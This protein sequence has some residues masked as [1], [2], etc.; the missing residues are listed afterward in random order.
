MLIRMH[1]TQLR[2]FIAL[3]D[4]GSFTR[5]AG[6]AHV[7]QPALSRSI[8]ML[9]EDLGLRLVDRLGKRCQVSTAGQAV[10]ARARRIVAEADELKRTGEQLR[11]ALAGQ[12][13]IGLGGGPGAVLTTALLKHFA[14]HHPAIRLTISRAPTTLLLDSLRE[15]KID[16]VVVDA[17]AV[18]PA[19]DLAIDILPEMAAGFFCRKGHPLARRKSIGPDVLGEFPVASAPLSDEISRLIVE[20]FGPRWHPNEFVTLWCDTV[21]STLETAQHTDAIFIGIAAAL[22][23]QLAR[24]RMLCLPLW[25]AMARVGRFGLITLAHRSEPP[26]LP[27]LRAFVREQLRDDP[28]WAAMPQSRHAKGRS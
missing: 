3:A 18:P 15:R 2:H 28:A 8:Q 7:T 11:G 6:A 9:E 10:L 24:D 1:L 26:A 12:L 21:E 25:P 17:R 14:V 4:S 13:G 16:M 23:E 19:P 27:L 20:R 22:R 5:A